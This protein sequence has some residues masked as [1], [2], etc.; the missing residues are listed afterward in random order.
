M[1]SCGASSTGGRDI[2]EDSRRP[3]HPLVSRNSWPT[4]LSVAQMK[5]LSRSWLTQYLKAS[6]LTN[7]SVAQMKTLS[8]SKDDARD[9]PERHLKNPIR[10]L[11]AYAAEGITIFLGLW[12]MR[13][14]ES[15]KFYAKHR[16]FKRRWYVIAS[17]RWKHT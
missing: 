3:G 7:P 9:L 12:C 11:H 1:E 6:R 13:G 10:N 15:P 17:S 4:N 14:L 2:A 16:G 8:R 5:T